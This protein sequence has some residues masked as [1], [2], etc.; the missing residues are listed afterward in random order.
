MALISSKRL[1]F[2]ILTS[3]WLYLILHSQLKHKK[4]FIWACK[5]KHIPYMDAYFFNF[6]FFILIGSESFNEPSLSYKMG[7]NHWNSVYKLLCCNFQLLHFI[8]DMYTHTQIKYLLQVL[9]T[10]MCTFGVN[11]FPFSN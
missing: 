6:I 4:T 3:L 5:L 9:L 11:W 8:F 1:H 7:N 10:N 2:Y